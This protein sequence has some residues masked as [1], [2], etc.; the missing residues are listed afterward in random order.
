MEV[1]VLVSVLRLPEGY[2]ECLH[3]VASIKDGIIVA[4]TPLK[5]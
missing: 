2:C 3:L 4:P 1:H 5:H